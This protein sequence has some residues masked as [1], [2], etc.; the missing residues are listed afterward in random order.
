M[1]ADV[2]AGL[3]DLFVYIRGRM[4]KSADVLSF[5]S[6]RIPT[7]PY[8]ECL[9]ITLYRGGAREPTP[10]SCTVAHP[11][12]ALTFKLLREDAI[13][14]SRLSEPQI[15]L[16]PFQRAYLR[17]DCWSIL[18]QLATETI[19]M[20]NLHAQLSAAYSELY[21]PAST[22]FHVPTGYR[23]WH[24]PCIVQTE[25]RRLHRHLS[26]LSA[27]LSSQPSWTGN[28]VGQLGTAVEHGLQELALGVPP[29]WITSHFRQSLPP[30]VWDLIVDFLLSSDPG[31]SQTWRQADIS[32][33]Q[34]NITLQSPLRIPLFRSLRLETDSDI[35]FLRNI[36]LSHASGWLSKYIE[37]LEVALADPITSPVASTTLFRKLPSLRV[38]K[39]TFSN[40]T[41]LARHP[42]ATHHHFPFTMRLGA[43]SLRCLTTLII[44]NYTLSSLESFLLYISAFSSLEKVVLKST[45][46]RSAPD[47]REPPQNTAPLRCM[48]YVEASCPSNW[49][50][51]WILAIPCSAAGYRRHQAQTLASTGKSAGAATAS[52]IMRILQTLLAPDDRAECSGIVGRLH[53]S[54]DG[55]AC[56]VATQQLC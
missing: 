4:P 32:D 19:V 8:N 39:Y 11:H 5:V 22:V 1:T 20:Q 15:H 7:M 51:A 47:S 25:L 12:G 44:D 45:R 24:R 21:K 43:R 53:Y 10:A 23:A 34:Q 37:H 28:V 30:E 52:I 50:L 36:L 31:L 27:R 46:W 6:W 40:F 35:H 16:P 9:A 49:V 56:N 17:D 3:R 14:A 38:L 48:K 55:E 29:R 26:G 13:L 2:E 18:S 41:T 54:G 42:G 33:F